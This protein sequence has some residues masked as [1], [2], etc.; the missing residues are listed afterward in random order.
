MQRPS[1]ESIELWRNTDVQ[2]HGSER[3]KFRAGVVRS[4]GRG[5]QDYAS[6]IFNWGRNTIRKGEK[7]LKSGIDVE[8]LFHLR[9]RKPAEHY[10]P[11]LLLHIKEII[12]P[13]S[14]TDPTFKS[15]RVYTP[16]TAKMVRERLIK[17]FDYKDSGL[18]VERTL[19]N[20]INGL[21][22]TLKK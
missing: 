11:N 9:G 18:P 19:S 4:I 7:E 14:Q 20:K 3:R 12:E 6:K 13:H 10:L 5:G 16:I 21:G 17:H 8:D 22:F 2:L 1:E 15:T